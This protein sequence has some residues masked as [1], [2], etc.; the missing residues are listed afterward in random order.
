ME[1]TFPIPIPCV[2]C[3]LSCYV[4]EGGRLVCPKCGDELGQREAFRTRAL[5]NTR[6]REQAKLSGQWSEEVRAHKLD[7]E[8]LPGPEA[9]TPMEH[10]T[11][12]HEME[13]Q[14]MRAGFDAMKRENDR[15]IRENAHLRARVGVLQNDIE[16]LGDRCARY[17]KV[18]DEKIDSI[19]ELVIENERQKREL[20]HKGGQLAERDDLISRVYASE[21]SA[22]QR[23]M[24]DGIDTATDKM[25]KFLDG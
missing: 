5:R 17:E 20:Q 2:A 4:I 9:M 12:R 23:G 25:R 1:P 13:M 22:Y 19:G 11:W 16:I 14:E 10:L 6:E 3:A 18:I 21:Q 24:A 7:R 8:N 15:L